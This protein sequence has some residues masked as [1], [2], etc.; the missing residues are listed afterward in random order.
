MC[1]Y[2]PTRSAYAHKQACANVCA[3]TSMY[4]PVYR[5]EVTNVVLVCPKSQYYSY[6]LE[7]PYARSGTH[8][9]AVSTAKG[10]TVLLFVISASDAQWA[11]SKDTLKQLAKSFSV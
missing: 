4:V 2:I 6:V 9:L 10:N 3:C 1:E 7:T 11:S 5:K 8:N